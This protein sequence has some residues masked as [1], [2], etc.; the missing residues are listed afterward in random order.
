[1]PSGVSRSATKALEAEE[2]VERDA[3]DAAIDS[4]CRRLDYVERP[5]SVLDGQGDHAAAQSSLPGQ[6]SVGR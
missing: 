4:W 2:F 3:C 6:C 5:R 1:M